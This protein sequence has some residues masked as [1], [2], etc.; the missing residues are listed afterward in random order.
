MGRNRVI[1]ETPPETQAETQAEAPPEIQAETQAEAQPEVQITEQPE[2]P[3]AALITTTETAQDDPT[4]AEQEKSA[5]EIEA[6]VVLSLTGACSFTGR[7][8]KR[9]RKGGPFVVPESKAKEL[10]ATGLFK[11]A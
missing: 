4:P 1:P 2:T 3:N 8:L 11:R 5:A 9:V 6:D 10:L 7:G